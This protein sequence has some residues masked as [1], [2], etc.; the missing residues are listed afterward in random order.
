[1]MSVACDALANARVKSA[2]VALA[3]ADDLPKRICL[4]LLHPVAVHS[5]V[6]VCMAALRFTWQFGVCQ[7]CVHSLLFSFLFLL[8]ALCPMIN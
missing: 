6:C 4:L 7:V 2:V 3:G 8:L 1:M 5:C